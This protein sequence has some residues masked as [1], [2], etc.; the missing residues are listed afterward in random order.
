VAEKLKDLGYGFNTVLNAIVDVFN[1][2]VAEVTSL[3]AQVFD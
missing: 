1:M 3:L 2:A